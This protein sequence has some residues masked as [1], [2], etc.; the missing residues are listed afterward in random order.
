MPE[1]RPKVEYDIQLCWNKDDISGIA[2]AE[3]MEANRA[4]RQRVVLP[5]MSCQP[6]NR[7]CA[8]IVTAP[9]R[10]ESWPFIWLIEGDPVEVF[11]EDHA[12]TNGG[13]SFERAAMK[14]GA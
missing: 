1:F 6:R 8:D 13:R 11:G 7:R 12:R 9:Y 2:E 10:P 3:R 14:G 4:L 5:S